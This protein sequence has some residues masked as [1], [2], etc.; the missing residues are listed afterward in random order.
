MMMPLVKEV[1]IHTSSGRGIL[2]K[3]LGSEINHPRQTFV[4]ASLGLLIL[5]FSWVSLVLLT[6]H[7]QSSPPLSCQALFRC[8]FQFFCLSQS[9]PYVW[10]GLYFTINESWCPLLFVFEF[11]RTIKVLLVHSSNIVNA[12]GTYVPSPDKLRLT[13]FYIF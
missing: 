9:F 1:Q 3:A 2:S 12:F 10:N 6:C 7:H 5:G 4:T 8:H 13:Y 11:T